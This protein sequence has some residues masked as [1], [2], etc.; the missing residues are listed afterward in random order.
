MTF[1]L[2]FSP[3]NRLVNEGHTRCIFPKTERDPRGDLA[4]GGADTRRGLPLYCTAGDF[5][6]SFLQ[7]SCQKLKSVP[8]GDRGDSALNLVIHRLEGSTTSSTGF[9]KDF[10]ILCPL[11]QI[12]IRTRGPRPWMPQRGLTVFDPLSNC[13]RVAQFWAH[14]GRFPVLRDQRGDQLHRP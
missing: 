7:Q 5:Y 12:R 2:L 3:S 4:G 9:L 10:E 8:Q 6:F 13:P 14:Q 1:A 11:E